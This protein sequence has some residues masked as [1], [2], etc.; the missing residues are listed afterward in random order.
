MVAVKV[1]VSS[2]EPHALIAGEASLLAAFTVPK[3]A[4]T[5]I[6]LVAAATLI[7]YVVTAGASQVIS[8]Q[9]HAAELMIILK[10]T[11]TPALAA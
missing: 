2:Q 8:W 3:G 10:A 4:V 11:S 1:E 7:V 9:S 6:G 5:E